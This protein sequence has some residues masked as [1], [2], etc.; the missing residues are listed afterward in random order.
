MY[1]GASSLM[2]IMIFLRSNNIAYSFYAN[3][4]I[5]NSIT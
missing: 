3:T 5:T 1:K 4:I 2:H